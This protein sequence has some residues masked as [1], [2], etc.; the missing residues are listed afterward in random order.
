[1]V[2]DSVLNSERSIVLKQANNRL[3]A[4]MAVLYHM[5]LGV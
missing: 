3:W 1:V 2:S 4:Q 5:L